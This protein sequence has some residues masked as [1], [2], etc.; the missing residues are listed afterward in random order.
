MVG[1][2]VYLQNG[3]LDVHHLVPPYHIRV[4]IANLCLVWQVVHSHAHDDEMV[5]LCHGII[6]ILPFFFLHFFECIL[7]DPW[8]NQ[9]KNGNFFLKRTLVWKSLPL[10]SFVELNLVVITSVGQTSFFSLEPLK[11][12]GDFVSCIHLK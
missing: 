2:E 9:L 6:V 8:H 10:Q 1:Q 11:Y 4:I 12:V 7:S 5:V 3:W